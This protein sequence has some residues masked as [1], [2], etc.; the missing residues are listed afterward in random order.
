[1]VIQEGDKVPEFTFLSLVDSK[2]TPIST[3][4]I[5]PGKKV[6]LVAIPGAFTPT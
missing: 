2:P 1:M 6:V 4:D 5:F 3:K